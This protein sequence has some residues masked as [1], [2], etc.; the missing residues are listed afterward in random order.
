MAA[1]GNRSRA[2]RLQIVADLAWRWRRFRTE[3]TRLLEEGFEDSASVSRFQKALSGDGSRLAMCLTID[4]F[5][6]T[7]AENEIVCQRS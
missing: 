2:R 6:V 7:E 4:K 1:K 3:A 5:V